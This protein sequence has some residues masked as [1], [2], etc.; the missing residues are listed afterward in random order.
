MTHQVLWSQ[1]STRF[2]ADTALAG[3]SGVV[4]VSLAGL[5]TLMEIVV[6]SVTHSRQ[7]P[8]KDR[9]DGCRRVFAAGLL[10]MRIVLPRR[11]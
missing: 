9:T 5:E 10:R 4:V 7:P 8:C 2:H 6:I 3:I 11:V 1:R